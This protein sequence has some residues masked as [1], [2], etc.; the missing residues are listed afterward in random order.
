MYECDHSEPV[1]GGVFL[2]LTNLVLVPAIAIALWIGRDLVTAT[3]LFLMFVVS[4]LYHV[5]EAGWWCLATCDTQQAA[6]HIMVYTL[7]FWIFLVGSTRARDVQFALLLINVASLVLFV[8][9][10][11]QTSF[12]GLLYVLFFIAWVIVEYVGFGIPPRP[13]GIGLVLIAIALAAV[14]LAPFFVGGDPGDANYWWTHSLWHFFVILAVIFLLL[15]LY[16]ESLWKWYH[17]LRG[18][19][20][21]TWRPPFGTAPP[22]WP[23]L[24]PAPYKPRVVVVRRS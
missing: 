11:T 2:V 23:K 12:F 17:E 1:V 10:T 15:A 18:D 20:Q 16:G 6:D 22:S 3:V 5:C 13:Y 19:V 7:V 21:R 9:V 14:G 8:A 4:T 24:G